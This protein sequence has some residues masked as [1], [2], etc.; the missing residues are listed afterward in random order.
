M[1]FGVIG[2]QSDYNTKEAMVFVLLGKD[3]AELMVGEKKGNFWV[4]RDGYLTAKGL[5]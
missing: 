1:Q 4:M 5:A 3:K 2:F